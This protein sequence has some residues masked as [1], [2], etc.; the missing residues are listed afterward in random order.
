[1]PAPDAS[2][3]DVNLSPRR[4]EYLA[5]A[6]GPDTLALLQRDARVYLHQSLSTPCLNALAS[7]RGSVLTDLGGREILDFHGNSAHQVGHAHPRVVEAVT[8]QLASL[9]FCPRRYTNEPA[10]RLA[11]RLGGLT[12]GRLPRVL[13]APGG[14]AA[15][16]IALKLARVA[17]GRFKFLST[18]GS[19]HGASLDTISIGG[20]AVFRRGIGPLLP[21]CE[22]A[23][24]CAPSSCALGCGGRC[25]LACAGEVEDILEREGDVAALILEPVRCTT[26]EVPPPDYFR[27]IRDACDRHGTLL[28]F[29]E[30]PTALGRTGRMFS[31]EHFGVE[32]DILVLGKGLGG[33]IVPQ[34]AVLA[35]DD[36]NTAASTSLGHYTH[37]KSPLGAA[38]ALAT[39]DVIRDE[40]LCARAE[41]LGHAWRARLRGLIGPSGLL[42][43]VRGLG[44]LVGVELTAGHAAA[45]A[46]LCDRV[47]YG[48]LERGLSFKVSDGRVLT[49]TPA[50]TVGED[51]LER[52]AGILAEC[53]TRAKK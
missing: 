50:L 17:T 34:A 14:A 16:G 4:G 15:M 7:A 40:G 43:E 24:P 20:E 19:F 1:M 32:P 42:R 46:D 8:R 11:E 52:A 36:L 21:G 39:L 27:R 45:T 25:S 9:P 10:V 6:H 22:H 37:E 5:R 47:L 26:V 48:A 51:E 35:R 53:I 12:G 44:L 38:A 3:G 30:I 2:E 13:L 33:G 28:I 41:R 18:W 31:F 29:D 49:L 23:Q